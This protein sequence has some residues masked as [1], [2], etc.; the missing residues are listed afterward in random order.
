MVKKLK[1]VYRA[2]RRIDSWRFVAF[3]VLLAIGIYTGSLFYAVVSGG[4][5]GVVLA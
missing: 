2:V 5:A 4:L 1:R 3:A